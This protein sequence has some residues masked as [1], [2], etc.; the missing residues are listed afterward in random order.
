MIL[1]QAQDV[2][3]AFDGVDLFTH[4]NLQVQEGG[5]VA[6]VGPN[7]I[8]KTTLLHILTGDAD[9]DYGHMTYKKGMSIGYLAQNSGLDSDKEI[10]AEMLDG[11]KELRAQ[12]KRVHE[13]EAEIADPA[14]LE[15][16]KRY[17]ETMT[18]YEQLAHDFREAGGYGYEAEIRN[19]LA[20]FNFPESRFHD[21]IATL[22]GG[23]RSRLALAKML[24][25]KH[26]L[27]ILDEPTNHLDIDTLTWLE[28]YLKGYPG[29]ILIVSHDQ[30]FLDHTVSE[31]YELSPNGA[32][33][34]HGNYTE[35]RQQRAANLEL[36]WKAYNK[37]QE[38]INKLQDFVD[39]NIVRASS[40]KRA[41]S[42]R[43]QLEKIDRLAKPT[44]DASAH[45]RFSAAKQSGNV[46]LTVS[47]AS[48]GYADG[49]VMAGPIDFEIHKGERIA[50][51]GPNGVGKSTLLKSVLGKI[52]FKT[53]TS[54]FGT[55]VTPG[56]YDQEQQNLNPKN[57]VL[58]EVW[59][60]HPTMPEREIRSALAAFLLTAEDVDKPVAALSG[61]Q[62]ARLT[63]TKLALNHDN[64]LILDEPTNHLDINSK[65]VLEAALAD[66]DGTVLFVSHDRYFINA[67]AQRTVAIS[68]KG[69]T[70]Y[71][72]NWDYYQEKIA[73]QSD[74]DAATTSSSSANQP[75]A[76]NKA[77]QASK[78]EQR[79]QRKLQR[80]V[81]D[82]ESQVDDLTNQQTAIETEMAKPENAASALKLQ[83]MQ[84]ELDAI[85]T[86]LSE[87]EDEWE[88]ASLELEDFNAKLGD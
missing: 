51:V 11:F 18:R 25:A 3:R 14:L 81:D 61:G 67:L 54:K 70:T 5:R 24:L 73:P 27:I 46:V 21:K 80:R 57:T 72:G 23:E 32:T 13:M 58:E 20:G 84:K 65:E 55:N 64:F 41:Q 79:A 87:A 1:L 47:D 31:V 37:Q 82:A 9:P 8:G 69:S 36:A 44:G 60:Q 71:L 7:G 77:Y 85:S 28:G 40:T 38:E 42:R 29:A 50:I 39:K 76:A 43:K 15:D 10:Y 17:D 75:S 83:D 12:E 26:D 35:Y 6:L 49:P 68:P 74:A 52:P 48:V 78:D 2:G 56:Y 19:V 53:G 16:K 88:N 30:Y 62:K 59:S 33:H 22:S 63:L 34:Y 66:F 4:I 86:Q 45:F